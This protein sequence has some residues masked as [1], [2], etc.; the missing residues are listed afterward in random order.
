M[1]DTILARFDGLNTWRQGDQR[2]AHKPL[3][4]LY[5]LGRWRCALRSD[6]PKRVGVLRA[7]IRLAPI[8][9][10]GDRQQCRMA[11]VD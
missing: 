5:A 3:L 8:A 6:R 9:Q 7:P 1:S 4:V 2:A 10:I 11:A